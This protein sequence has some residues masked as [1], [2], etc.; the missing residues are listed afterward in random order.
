MGNDGSLFRRLTGG[1]TIAVVAGVLSAVVLTNI[2]LR[3]IEKNIPSTLLS[4]LDDLAMTL[5]RLSD[6]VGLRS[7]LP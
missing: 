3:S 2:T 7:G 6:T 1:F 5:E 4:E